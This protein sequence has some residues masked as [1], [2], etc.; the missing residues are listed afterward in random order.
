MSDDSAL[1]RHLKTAGFFAGP[2]IALVLYAWNPGDHPPEARRLLAI[3]GLA[4]AYWITEAIPL[5][6]TALARVVLGDRGRGRAGE[7]GPGPLRRP[8]DL[9]VRGQLPALRGLP[10]VRPRRAPGLGH[11]GPRLLRPHGRRPHGGDR[12]GLG[13]DLHLPLEHGHRRPHDAH[14][15]RHARRSRREDAPRGSRLASGILLM[16]AYGA[17]IGGMA[18]IIGTPPN[19]LVAGFLER[20]AGVRITFTG[21][22][23]FALPISLVLLA[24]SRSSDPVR[25]GRGPGRGRGGGAP[26]VAI[27]PPRPKRA[28]ATGPTATA[29]AGPWSR[30]AWRGSSGRCPPCCPGCSGATTR[31]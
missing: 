6:A 27:P 12:R 14:R 20:L 3:L 26:P 22:S 15:A 8:R 30:S 16:V 25:P 7:A 17:S 10:Q 29:L 19:L 11:P 13:R 5:P 9:P 31:S 4:I 28:E 21:W 1:E 2:A 24:R 23:A 18:T